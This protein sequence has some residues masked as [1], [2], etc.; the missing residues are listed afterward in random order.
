[1]RK[2]I[3]N[4]KYPKFNLPNVQMINFLDLKRNKTIA[5]FNSKWTRIRSE[6]RSFSRATQATKTSA[7]SE[8]GGWMRASR[9]KGIA[10]LDTRSLVEHAPKQNAPPAERRRLSSEKRREFRL[11]KYV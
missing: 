9:E 1:M 11:R 10:L 4:I 7:G 8:P 5:F 2:N 6:M 3:L